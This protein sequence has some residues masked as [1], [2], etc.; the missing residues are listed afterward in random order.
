MATP[1]GVLLRAH[2]VRSSTTRSLD[3]L[4]DSLAASGLGPA[5]DGLNRPVGFAEAER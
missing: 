5:N 1:T 3:R 2:R 4:R